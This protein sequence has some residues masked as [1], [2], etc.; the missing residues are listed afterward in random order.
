M[1]E[2][3]PQSL[4][5]RKE[6]FSLAYIHAVAARAGYELLETRVDIDSADGVLRSTTGRRPSIDFQAKATSRQNIQDGS[7]AFPLPMKNYDDLRAE[8]VNPRILIVV[9]LPHDEADWMVH[10]EDQ[11]ILRRC[12]YWLSLRERPKLVNQA[13]VTVHIPRTQ[14]FDPSQLGHMMDRAALGPEI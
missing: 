10:N 9:I 8:T 1:S 7:L 2:G 12:G 13:R 4:N 3:T 6:R 14:V 11:L 5:T